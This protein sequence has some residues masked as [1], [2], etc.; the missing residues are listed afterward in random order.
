MEYIYLTDINLNIV[1]FS[2]KGSLCLLSTN[3]IIIN[4]YTFIFSIF[5]GFSVN[6][7]SD[8]FFVNNKTNF[9]VKILHLLL[10]WSFIKEKHLPNELKY[11]INSL[12]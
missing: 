3:T 6:M 10:K 7:V 1:I 12:I 9:A 11:C 2:V 5:I 4:F 8:R